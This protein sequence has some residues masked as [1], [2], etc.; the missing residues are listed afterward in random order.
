MKGEKEKERKE[1]KQQT[2]HG[3]LALATPLLHHLLSPYPLTPFSLSLSFSVSHFASDRRIEAAGLKSHIG[4]S[5][6]RG[7]YNNN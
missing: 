7:K 5:K 3:F 2:R 6:W 4:R 1:Q